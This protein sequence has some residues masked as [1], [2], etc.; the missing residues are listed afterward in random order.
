MKDA[1]NSGRFGR[2]H[3]VP[4]FQV[5]TEMPKV[6]GIGAFAH[7]FISLGGQKLSNPLYLAHKKVPLPPGSYYRGT[8]PATKR[9]PPRTPLEPLAKAY[10]WVLGEGVFT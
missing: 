7:D 4:E 6:A 3:E 9:P 10:C 5:S 2:E 8:S 1:P